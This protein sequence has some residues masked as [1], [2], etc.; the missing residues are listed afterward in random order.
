[1]LQVEADSKYSDVMETALFNN[2]L[3]G[4]SIEGDKFYYANPL[5]VNPGAYENRNEKKGH[6]TVERQE[7]FGCACCPPNFARIIASLG[8][9]IY[10]HNDDSIAV[11]LYVQSKMSV[12]LG[13]GGTLSLEMSTN[14]P[15]DGAIKIKLSADTPVRSTLR[16]RIPGW[17]KSYTIKIGGQ[18]IIPSIDHGYACIDRVWQDGDSI[19]L[20]LAMPV[21]RVVAHPSVTADRGKIALQRGPLVYCIEDAD[22]PAGVDTASLPCDAEFSTVFSNNTLGGV[23]IVEGDALFADSDNWEGAIYQDAESVKSRRTRI[24]AIPYY[25]WD[26]RSPGRMMVWIP[27]APQI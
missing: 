8:S 23:V 16:L 14:Y 12:E 9:Y 2:I 22:N 21:E 24:R 19:E 1:M 10:S 3:G 27:L 25:A 18:E 7:W 5:S 11:H 20:D 13:K 4:V 15:W 26:N 6:V 17:C